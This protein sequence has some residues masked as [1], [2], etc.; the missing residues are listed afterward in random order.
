MLARYFSSSWQRFS[1]YSPV[2]GNVP[3]VTDDNRSGPRKTAA[4]N[5]PT[6]ADILSSRRLRICLPI[7]VILLI[8][9]VSGH[10]YDAL[11]RIPSGWAKGG[12][13]SN[14][15]T[16]APAPAVDSIVDASKVDWSRF[17]Y[18]QYVTDSHYLRNSVMLF[19]RLQHVGSRAD[20]VLMYPSYMYDP[21]AAWDG[22]VSDNAR[23]VMKARDEY[24][25]Q[26]VPIEV[27]HRDV[28]D[29]TWAESFTKLLAFNQTQYDRVLSLD[30]DSVVLQNMDELFLLP[31]CPM[32]MPRAYWLYPETKILTSSLMLLQPSA[33]EFAR[34]MERVSHAAPSDYD[35]EIINYLYADSAMVLP[36]RIY[37][38]LVAEYVREPD[39]HAAFLGNDREEWDAVAAFNEAKYLHWS[40]WPLPKPWLDIPE[41]ARLDREP[42]CHMRNGVES[43]AERDLWNG[44]YQDFAERRKRVCGSVPGERSHR[45]RR[46]G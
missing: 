40:D 30:S 25:A 13:S 35:M 26:L 29:K 19:E 1:S 43:C 28:G 7:A 21:N 11:A 6:V 3:P 16:T 2:N 31:P 27:Q 14:E 23:L 34:V 39:Q 22:V 37:Q 33:A 5:C 20:R 15:Q 41:K 8:L 45:L 4:R 38:L 24:G 10:R 46:R 17:A 44:F 18:T 32:A 42:K 9:V 12:A 36:H